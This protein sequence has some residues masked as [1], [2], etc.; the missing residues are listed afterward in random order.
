MGLP[1]I[2]WSYLTIPPTPSMSLITWTRMKNPSN[3]GSSP[4][5]GGYLE[6][7]MDIPRARPT[8][9]EGRGQ[10]ACGARRRLRGHRWAAAALCEEGVRRHDC[11]HS[12]EE[13]AVGV[14]EGRGLV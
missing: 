14:G 6:R 3:E 5:C 11:R 7:G 12:F 8:T 1:A 13:L 9:R 4:K 2:V 10:Q